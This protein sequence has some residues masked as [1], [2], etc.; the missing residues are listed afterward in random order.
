MPSNTRF[1]TPLTVAF[2]LI[3]ACN[4]PPPQLVEIESSDI[5]SGIYQ[6]ELTSVIAAERRNEIV[7]S[8]TVTNIADTAFS[9]TGIPIDGETGV[10]ERP[11][12][13]SSFELGELKVTETTKAVI[14]AGDRVSVSYDEVLIFEG[15]PLTGLGKA[16]YTLNT[17]GTIT[18]E[19]RLN[20]AGTDST[21]V[22]F[23][24]SIE[25]FGVLSK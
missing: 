19:R 4:S 1:I 8:D 15:E 14:V 17:D 20:V 25:T 3:A 23:V 16:T 12:L 21:G 7:A 22:S 10:T 24:I 13:V 6:G 11:G 2:S 18:V 9:N 5:P